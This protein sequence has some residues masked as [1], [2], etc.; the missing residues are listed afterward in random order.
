MAAYRTHVEMLTLVAKAL[1]SDLCEQETFVGGCTTA[2]LLTDEYTT[3]QV[4]QFI[5]LQ[6]PRRRT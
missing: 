3:E 5:S 4:R 2:L 1:G 6:A